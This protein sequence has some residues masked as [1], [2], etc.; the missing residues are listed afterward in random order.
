M[1]VSHFGDSSGIDNNMK[2]DA[3]ATT[4]IAEAFQIYKTTR[5]NMNNITVEHAVPNM[6]EQ[7]EINQNGDV[8]WNH[9]WS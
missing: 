4:A 5:N 8:L 6:Y 2:L 1:Q 9:P 3:A 7:I